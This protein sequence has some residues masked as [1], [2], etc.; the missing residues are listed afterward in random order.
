[1]LAGKDVYYA[2]TLSEQLPIEDPVIPNDCVR[3][4]QDVVNITWMVFVCKQA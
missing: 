4:G 1:M 3:D 2:C